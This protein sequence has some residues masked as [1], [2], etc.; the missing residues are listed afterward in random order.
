[1][2]DTGRISTSSFISTSSCVCVLAIVTSLGW[3]RLEVERVAAEPHGERLHALGER[4]MDELRVDDGT[5]GRAGLNQRNEDVDE[6]ARV[7][8]DERC[9]EDALVGGIDDQLHHAGRL[10]AL[11]G[12]G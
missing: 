7:D 9:A 4:R 10:V 5:R 8:A 12:A 6:L 3:C 11:D 1:M 2:S